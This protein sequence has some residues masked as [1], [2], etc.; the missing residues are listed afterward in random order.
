MPERPSDPGDLYGLPLDRF[1]PERGALARALRSQGRR[2]EAGGVA[3]LRKPSVAA[4]AV[5]QL[6]RTQGGAIAELFEAGEDLRRAQDELLAG[7]GNAAELRAAGERERTAAG[8]LVATARGL[9]GSEGQ[10][11]SATVLDRVADTLHAAAFDDEARAQV[12][13]GRLV[14]ELRHVGLGGGGANAAAAPGPRASKPPRSGSEPMPE[15][16]ADQRRRDR[17]QAAAKAAHK[18]AREAESDARRRAE[19]AFRGVEV[20]EQRRDRAAAALAES[21]ARL[22]AAREQAEATAAAHNEARQALAR[23]G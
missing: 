20:A 21:E 2:D 13:D 14:R 12:R 5:N 3:Q 9:L 6:V 11:L 19:R 16:A 8:E 10:E 1:V 4:W 17:K 15:A 18:A 22:V 7:R 23:L